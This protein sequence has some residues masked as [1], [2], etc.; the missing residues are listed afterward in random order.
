MGYIH[1]ALSSHEKEEM[2][3]EKDEKKERKWERNKMGKLGRGEEERKMKG[4]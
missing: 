2:Y 3:A 4:R 1:I